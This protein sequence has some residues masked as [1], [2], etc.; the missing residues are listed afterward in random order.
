LKNEHGDFEVGKHQQILLLSARGPWNDEALKN[1]SKKL[2]NLIRTLDLTSP[3]GQ[4]SCLY[5]ESLMPP[6]AYQYFVEQSKYRKK[7]GLKALAVIIKETDIANTIKRQLNEAFEIVG[8]KYE[9]FD[10]VEASAK[11]LFSQG[12]DADLTEIRKILQ[13]HNLGTGT[14]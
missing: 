11:W 13:S 1:G 3:W 4:I 7:L 2:A 8:L 14:E 10:S 9:F 6:T 12:L 5:G